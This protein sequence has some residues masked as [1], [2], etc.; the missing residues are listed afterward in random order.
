M[1]TKKK[2]IL[3]ADDEPDILE[4]ISYNLSKEGYEV[5]TA[6]D[7]NEAIRLAMETKPQL[8][9][10]DILMPYKSGMEVCQY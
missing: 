8:L 9:I 7:G 6:Q 3:I 10:L 5:V 1:E 4:I 2:S